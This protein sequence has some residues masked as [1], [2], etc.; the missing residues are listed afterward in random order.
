MRRAGCHWT[1]RTAGSAGPSELLAAIALDARDRIH[2]RVRGI[3]AGNLPVFD[4]FF[5]SHADRFEWAHPD[6][7]CVAFPRY[8]GPEGV[9]VFCRELVET[10]GVLLLPASIYQ[11]RLAP[12]PADR[13]RIGI[14]RRDPR[15][16]LEATARFL[17]GRRRPS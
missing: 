6:G 17:A 13:F 7:G 9:E 8:L 12:V 10:E 16:A 4:D 1:R 15:P 5:A 14:G 11:S 3:L 2:E